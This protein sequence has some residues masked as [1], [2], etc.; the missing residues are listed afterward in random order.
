[1]SI[2]TVLFSFDGRID[3]STYW[4]KGYLPLIGLFLVILLLFSVIGVS[5]LVAI[6]ILLS[7]TGWMWLAIS[8]KRW[9]DRDK[10][11]W[12]SLIGFVPIV[13]IWMF[14]E[15]G[16]LEGTDG[17]NRYGPKAGDAST[18]LEPQEVLEMR[19]TV[20]GVQQVKGRIVFTGNFW[21]YCFKGLLV[22]VLMLILSPLTL[23]LS[24]MYIPYWNVE[25][26]FAHMEIELPQP[27]QSSASSRLMESEGKSQSDAI[28]S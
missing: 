6:L 23:G 28:G 16:F 2:T 3:R 4:Q 13:S 19:G 9:H 27:P 17:P 24:L 11:G 25:Y 14:I 10:S 18:N 8:A 22:T 20:G 26:F 12:W 5:G 21:H 1:M 7:V 15:L